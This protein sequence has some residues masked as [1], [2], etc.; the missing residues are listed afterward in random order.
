[1]N[2]VTTNKR[3][4]A[5]QQCRNNWMQHLSDSSVAGT[6]K[7]LRDKL[8]DKINTFYIKLVMGLLNIVIK[9]AINKPTGYIYD[10]Q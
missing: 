3:R 8:D 9:L 10:S 7:T 5:H 1:M 4:L 2:H 6:S